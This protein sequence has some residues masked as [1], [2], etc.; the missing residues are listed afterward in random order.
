MRHTHI[1][2]VVSHALVDDCGFHLICMPFLGGAT[3]AA[4][5]AEN[6]RQ[7]PVAS[8]TDLLREPRHRCRAP[9][10]PAS[11]A[12]RPAREI[13]A[14]LSYEQAVAWIGATT[15]ADAARL[16]FQVKMSPHGDVKP[17]NILLT[18][19]GSPMLLDFNLARDG[20]PLSTIDQVADAGRTLAYMAPEQHFPLCRP[21]RQPRSILT[22]S[23]KPWRWFR[24]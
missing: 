13:L 9:E 18:A 16:R 6:G 3:L 2:E 14:A 4:V 11:G 10:F 7:W 17:S 24:F 1:V 21:A 19:D 15:P 8:G 20:S 22:A 12:V 23:S 5:M